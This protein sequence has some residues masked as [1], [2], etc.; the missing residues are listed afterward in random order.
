MFVSD[1]SDIVAGGLVLCFMAVDDIKSAAVDG[2]TVEVVDDG[3]VD[4]DLAIDTRGGEIIFPSEITSSDA[5]RSFSLDIVVCETDSVFSCPDDVATTGS[6]GV[7]VEVAFDVGV[8]A[9]QSRGFLGLVTSLSIIHVKVQV[10][11][12]TN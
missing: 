9:G 8:D 3:E 1:V 10:T 11:I 4:I 2:V 6:D 12:Y 7:N 5:G